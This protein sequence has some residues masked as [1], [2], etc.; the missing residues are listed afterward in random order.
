MDNFN[1]HDWKIHKILDETKRVYIC[2][3]RGN[4]K[5]YTQLELYSELMAQNKEIIFV[6]SADLPK[7][8][9]WKGRRALLNLDKDLICNSEYPWMQDAIDKYIE[10]EMYKHLR[11]DV[12]N[13]RPK[14]YL[15]TSLINPSDWYNKQLTIMDSVLGSFIVAPE[16]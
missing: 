1:H 15:D 6:R 16:N 14:V 3:A 4:D 5:L 12:E 7:K 10:E 11:K 9:S 13:W 2:P 8:Y